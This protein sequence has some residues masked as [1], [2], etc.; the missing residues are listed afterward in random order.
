MHPDIQPAGSA[1]PSKAIPIWFV[2]AAAGAPFAHARCRGARFCPRLAVLS[3]S[4]THL[5]LPGAGGALGAVLFGLEKPDDAA[6]RF[7]PGSL[8]GLLPDGLYRFANAPHDARLAALAFALG[9]YRFTRYR[10]TER[11]QRSSRRYR[12][13]SMPRTSRASSMA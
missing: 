7:C 12:M 8:A 11:P 4:R 6:D 2:T 10:K 3:P 1:R 5:A 13:A 9:A